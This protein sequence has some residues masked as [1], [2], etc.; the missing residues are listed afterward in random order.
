[1]LEEINM[2]LCETTLNTETITIQSNNYP[3]A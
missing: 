1:M 3:I 2:S